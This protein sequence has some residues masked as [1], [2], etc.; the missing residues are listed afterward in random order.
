[1]VFRFIMGKDSPTNEALRIHE[2]ACREGELGYIDPET[3]LFVMTSVYLLDQGACCGSGCRHCPFSD[4]E[5]RRAGRPPDAEAWPWSE[6]D[7][8]RT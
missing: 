6:A 3:G 1:M 7:A 8:D 5:R 2:A 4:A